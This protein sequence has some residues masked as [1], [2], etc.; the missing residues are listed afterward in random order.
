MPRGYPK[1]KA[2]D[3]T[4]KNVAPV[5][6]NQFQDAQDNDVGQDNPRLMKTTGKAKDALE[7]ARIIPVDNP[8]L[9]Q[10]KLANMAFMEE[11][12]EIYIQ[13]TSDK[14]A[15][16]IFDVGCNGQREFF[17]RGETKAVKRKFVNI[18]AG[19][20]ITTFTQQRRQ[21]K[22]GIFEDVQIPTTSL[23]YPFSVTRDDNPLGAH[24]LRSVLAQA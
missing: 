15:A 14:Q 20:K 9:D 17:R 6:L 4:P 23:A 24:W 1:A 5:A 8:E 7:P 2:A 22:E 12:V 21:N 18:L 13:P 10:E 16:P 3:P 11:M 19:S